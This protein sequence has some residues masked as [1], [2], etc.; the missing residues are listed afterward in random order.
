MSKCQACWQTESQ[1]LRSHEKRRY[2]GTAKKWRVPRQVAWD[3]W[4]RSHRKLGWGVCKTHQL[5]HCLEL[6]NKKEEGECWQWKEKGASLDHRKDSTNPKTCFSSAFSS[7][8][9][10]KAPLLFSSPKIDNKLRTEYPPQHTYTPWLHSSPYL[11]FLGQC[12]LTEDSPRSRRTVSSHMV[13]LPA[14]AA[15]QR[16][17]PD[18]GWEKKQ[19]PVT[20]ADHWALGDIT[21]S[22]SHSSFLNTVDWREQE[23]GWICVNSQMP[24]HQTL[25]HLLRLNHL[26]SQASPTS[27]RESLCSLCSPRKPHRTPGSACHLQAPSNIPLPSHSFPI[28]EGPISLKW[29]RHLHVL[30]IH[31]GQGLPW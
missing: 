19:R 15:E 10:E 12:C 16:R 14:A 9:S 4:S 22:P 17:G 20:S 30:K 13:D 28:Q 1:G 21:A 29:E 5:V 18:M 6:Q 26:T 8:N 27:C 3:G 23:T 11:K 31:T 25:S 24:Q 7:L 2:P